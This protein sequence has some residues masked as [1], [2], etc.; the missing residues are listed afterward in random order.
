MLFKVDVERAFRNLRVDSADALKLG[1]KWADTYYMDLA[2]VFVWMHG[3][4]SFQILSDAIAYIMAN[5][6]VK[7]HCY[8]DD[9]IAVAP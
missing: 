6:G 1:I 5:K 9:Y 2:I 8:I 7:L 3:S 4:G